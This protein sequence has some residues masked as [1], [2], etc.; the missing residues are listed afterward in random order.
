MWKVNTA[1]RRIAVVFVTGAIYD[2]E[3]A[4]VAM[5]RPGRDGGRRRTVKCARHGGIFYVLW[6]GCR[7]KALPKVAR[8]RVRWHESRSLERGRHV[9]PHPSRA[10]R[11]GTRGG[12]P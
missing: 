8:R 2:A 12:G 9:G 3:S 4:I 6:T 11:G 1:L 7:W 10:V 5:I